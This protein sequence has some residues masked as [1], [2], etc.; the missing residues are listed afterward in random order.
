MQYYGVDGYM[1]SICCAIHGITKA[2]KGI[3]MEY[4]VTW[5]VFVVQYMIFQRHEK[6]L[7]WSK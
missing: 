6:A 2:P 4:K 3:V 5:L 1:A 7:L